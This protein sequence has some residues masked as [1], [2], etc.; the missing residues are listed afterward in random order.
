MKRN[1]SNICLMLLPIIYII[2]YEVYLFSNYMQHIEF[3]TA[4]FTILLFSLSIYLLGFRKNKL[5][6]TMKNIKNLVITHI[7]M[8]FAIIYGCGLLLGYLENGYSLQ[9]GS[10]IN[11]TFGPLI[12]IICIELF[13]YVFIK[14]N[15]DKLTIIKIMTVILIVFEFLLSIKLS[16][17]NNIQ[18]IFKIVTGTGLPI[19]M[20]N[21]TMSYLSYHVGFQTTLLYRLVMD[22]YLYIVPIVPD[23]GDYINSILGVGLPFLIYLNSSKII[24]EF[25]NGVEHEFLE[26]CFGPH[27]LVIIG[28]IGCLTLLCSRMLPWYVI[29]V[30]SESM[31]PQITKGDAVVIEKVKKPED[32]KKGNVLSFYKEGKEI[33][34]RFVEIE[35][36]DGTICYITKGDANQTEDMGCLKFEDITGIVKVKI[37]YVAYPRV[38]LSEIL[39]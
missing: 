19:I 35:E 6:I 27:D 28:V 12:T 17:F 25:N 4:S 20:K 23:L 24:D 13:R 33:V 5:N 18:N 9:I 21:I 36:K 11:N 38:F 1:I 14:A 30:A 37:P 15:T 8:Y 29:G 31:N 39:G 10:I 32:I 34:H 26:S 22:L 2:L 3:I 16:N 7:V